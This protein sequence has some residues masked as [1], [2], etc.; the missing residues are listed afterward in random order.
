MDHFRALLTGLLMPVAFGGAAWA[1]AA[2]GGRWSV[3]LDVL[4][5]FA[6][7]VLFAGLATAIYGVLFE[8]G[9]ARR[10]LLALGIITIASSASLIAPE[11][12]RPRSEPLP[13]GAPDQIK[14]IQF[15]AWGRNQS[16]PR[17]IEWL[18]A[19]DADIIVVEEASE[20]G[21]MLTKALGYHVNCRF[22]SVIILSKAAPVSRKL[23]PMP[24]ER[25]DRPPVAR[26]TFRDARGEYTV[27][28][29]H[30]TWPIYGGWQ[31]AQGAM[32][33]RLLDTFP[34][35]RLILA[36]DFNSTP[37][38]FSRRRED[39]TFGLERRT[40]AVFSWPAGRFSRL[41][42]DMPFPLLPIDHVY[43][44]AGWRTV[45]VERGPLLGSDHYPVIV[46]LAPSP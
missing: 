26:A 14:L 32:I 22:C 5:H 45:D 35:E 21:P 27:I 33:S 36:G 19:Q 15:N 41:Q 30:L 31:Q 28:G 44:G 1:L 38:S 7:L 39:A 42:I 46:T 11:Y 4:T 16:L 34:K 6:P 13:A 10:W 40:R 23:P 8:S 3:R 25:N 43:A 18:K 37:W 2:Q 20:I 29:T 9:G 12:L 17:T 24:G